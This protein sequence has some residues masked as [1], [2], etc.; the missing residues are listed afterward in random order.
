MLKLIIDSLTILSSIIFTIEGIPQ[1]IKLYKKKESKS[2]SYISIIL[3]LFGLIGY[4]S[5]S[6][7]YNFIEIYPFIIIQ[8]VLKIILI[9]EKIYYDFYYV[10]EFSLYESEIVIK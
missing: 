7:Y 4:A 6:L 2:I 1:I 5:F 8:I 9:S 10:K 3:G